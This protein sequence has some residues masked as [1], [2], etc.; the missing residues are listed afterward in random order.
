[1]RNIKIKRQ[2]QVASCSCLLIYESHEVFILAMFFS[3]LIRCDDAYGADDEGHAEELVDVEGEVEED[4][5]EDNGGEGFYG[6]D[7]AGFSGKDV[8]HT[9]QVEDEGADG[10]EEDDESEGRKDGGIDFTGEGG[11]EG[12]GYHDDGGHHHTPAD[13]DGS[14][15]FLDDFHWL[16]GVEGTGKS[17]GEA[18]DEGFFGN[19]KFRK[20]AA[21]GDHGGACDGEE[22]AED[23]HDVGKSPAPDAEPEYD[24]NGHEVFQYGGGRGIAVPDA[25]EIAVLGAHHA[26]SAEYEEGEPVFPFFPYGENVSVFHCCDGKEKDAGAEE[27]EEGEP[28]RRNILIQKKILACNA[29][30][31]PENRSD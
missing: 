8:G 26:E 5:G 6:G 1:M 10:A 9:S 14:A 27:A 21:G 11:G 13:D 24:E 7:D 29:A 20:V 22:G 23:F 16:D 4:E 2:L 28:F 25:Y 12:H 31:S 30:A 15:V 3:F 19:G 18:P 17:T